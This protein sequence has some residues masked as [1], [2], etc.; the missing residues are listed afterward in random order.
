MAAA[1][2]VLPFLRIDHRFR[3][4]SSE[5][6]SRIAEANDSLLEQT[7]ARGFGRDLEMFRDF[8]DQGPAVQ[9]AFRQRSQIEVS[10]IAKLTDVIDQRTDRHEQCAAYEA[11]LP[12][13]QS[14]SC[15]ETIE[16]RVHRFDWG[17]GSAMFSKRERKAPSSL[18]KTKS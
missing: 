10:L 1:P 16:S 8:A 17:K 14:R 2:D 6:A 18:W 13:I 12:S 4:N 9:R 15:K 5:K 3:R 7:N 11:G